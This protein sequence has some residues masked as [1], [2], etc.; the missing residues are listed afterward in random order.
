MKCGFISARFFFFYTFSFINFQLFFNFSS[1]MMFTNWRFQVD[2][3][4]IPIA[5]KF[6]WIGNMDIYPE[7]DFPFTLSPWC[8]VFMVSLF[9]QC[10]ETTW[11]APWSYFAANV[12]CSHKLNSLSHVRKRGWFSQQ[13][14]KTIFRIRSKYFRDFSYVLVGIYVYTSKALTHFMP[15][16]S[17]Y[18][19]W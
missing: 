16:V 1:V 19:P 11:W 5:F 8:S 18:T 9:L 6:S 14:F 7:L 17:F 15:L 12:T 3:D 13:I 2:P 10:I 4:K